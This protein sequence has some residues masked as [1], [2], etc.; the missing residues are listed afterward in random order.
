MGEQQKLFGGEDLQA[1][2][3]TDGEEKQAMPVAAPKKR[4]FAAMDPKLVSEIARKGGRA[5]HAQGTA[6]TFTSEEAKAAGRKGGQ[7]THARR[8]NKLKE[9]P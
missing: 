1:V 3:R 7:T 2:G 9:E 4:G 6:H 8:T 5:A